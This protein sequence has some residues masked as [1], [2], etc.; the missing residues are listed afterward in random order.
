VTNPITLY[1]VILENRITGAGVGVAFCGPFSVRV[2]ID[3]GK[4]RGNL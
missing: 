3:D 4:F 2:I 1:A